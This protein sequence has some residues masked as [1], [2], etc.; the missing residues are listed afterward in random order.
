MKNTPS[1]LK[2]LALGL[3]ASS[4][5]VARPALAQTL[6]PDFSFGEER[7]RV[8]FTS[9]AEGQKLSSVS[10][11]TKKSNGDLPV[12]VIP[13][14]HSGAPGAYT[15]GA[16]VLGTSDTNGTKTAL[17]SPAITPT[18]P[19]A[20]GDTVYFS[21]VVNILGS[22]S[23]GVRIMIGDYGGANNTF[24]ALTG[25]GLAPDDTIGRLQVYNGSSIQNVPHA[26]DDPEAVT[27]LSGNWYELTLVVQQNQADPANSLGYLFYRNLSTNEGLTLVDT[28]A[29]NGFTIDL[30]GRNIADFTAFQL[31]EFRYGAQIASITAGVGTLTN[32]PEAS[33]M[34]MAGMTLTAFGFAFV[35]NQRR[36]K[37]A[38]A[39]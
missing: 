17:E 32:I 15:P 27:L 2:S 33:A 39:G 11:W 4:L 24:R 23:S 7:V 31:T 18:T 8:D 5:L 34:T 20:A 38:M 19:F 35:L 25:F 6:L 12:G 37:A 10:G 29:S 28:T 9:L 16:I 14:K 1:L 3:L 26:K 36:R 21:A 30:T 13:R 22:A